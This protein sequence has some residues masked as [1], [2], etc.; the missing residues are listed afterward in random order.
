MANDPAAALVKLD[1]AIAAVEAARDLV[2]DVPA[3]VG[4]RGSRGFF[5]P[6]LHDLNVLRGRVAANDSASP[7]FGT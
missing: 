6:V 4:A 3:F 7:V 1:E 2:D 5:Q